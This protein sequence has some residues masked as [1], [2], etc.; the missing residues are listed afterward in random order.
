M[1]PTPTPTS[2]TPTSPTPI[3]TSPTPSAAPGQAA[4]LA[5]LQEFRDGD[6]RHVSMHGQWVA[7]IASKRVGTVDPLQTT[8]SGSHRFLAADILA[9][10]QNLRRRFGSKT[11]LL[12]SSDYGHNVRDPQGHVLWVTFYLGRFS[13]A[14]DV[15]SWCPGAFPELS[16]RALADTCAARP[17]NPPD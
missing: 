1:V 3:S 7:Q 15:L 14:Q 12:L 2:A 13:S 9:E 4:A 16:A 5:A 17:L 8:E 11:V 10:H 6:L